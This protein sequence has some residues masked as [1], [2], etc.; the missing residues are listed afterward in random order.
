M[1]FVRL[2]F[3]TVAL[4]FVAFPANAAQPEINNFHVLC[5][6]NVLDNPLEDPEKYT[7]ST[8]QLTQQF[9]WLKEQ[10]YK[11]IT[12]DDL[13]AARA[14][15]RPLPAKAVMLT[16]DDGYRSFYTHVFPLLKEF[17]YPAVL[18][19]VGSW[20]ELKPGEKAQY[21]GQNYTRE[22]FLNTAEIREMSSS[23]LVEVAS[24]SYNLHH[25][26]LANPQGNLL[27][28]SISRAYDATNNLYENDAEYLSRVRSDLTKNTKFIRRLTGKRPRVMVWPFGRYNMA[29]IDVAHSLG[30]PITFTLDGGINLMKDPLWKI[31]R[32]VIESG[33]T[34]SQLSDD[35]SGSGRPPPERVVHVDIDNIYDPDPVVQENQLGRLL[36][37]IK[38]LKVT[39]VYLQAFADP[40]GNGAA[41][42]V[43]FPNRHLPMRADLFSR[44]AWQLRTRAGVKVFAW[45]PL[46]AFELP[47]GSLSE[48]MRVASDENMKSKDRYP[49]LSPF[50]PKVRQL[51]AE[52]YEDLGKNAIFDGI[53]FHDDATLNEYEDASPEALDYYSREWGLPKSIS[54][55]RRD[56]VLLKNWTIHK[57][58]YLTEFSL[59][60]S[61][62][63]RQFQPQLKTARNLYAEVALNPDS[64]ERFAQS[65]TDFLARY[66]YTAVMAMPYMENAS[67]PLPWLKNLVM[68]VAKQP[69]ALQKT[70]FELQSF[71]WRTSKK[72]D[73]QML[74]KQMKLLQ[75]QGALNFGY[76][77]DDF[78]NDSPSFDVIKPYFSLQV[79]PFTGK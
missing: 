49:R 79:F 43:Y 16:F 61:N 75:L 28:A 44:V 15:R 32:V 37:R 8:E 23:G 25:G 41:D 30:M 56:P 7:I 69:N 2:I 63:V 46:L 58:R 12:V 60:I 31:H 6:H 51:I 35:L 26:I 59:E 1:I 11:V 10:G 36:D 17:K 50:D 70:V 34:V 42:S 22:K 9:S 21:E 13:I 48:N 77:P 68:E 66:D 4:L 39:T 18:A 54:E 55:I 57:T 53:L 5:Y 73:S 78:M 64:E 52:I 71:D 33:E 14:N 29:V 24:H 76:Y 3:Y 62:V 19:L 20:L 47:P 74:V 45:M 38:S 27:P 72:V 65:L 40:D 67:Q